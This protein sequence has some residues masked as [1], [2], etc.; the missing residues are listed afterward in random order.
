MLPRFWPVIYDQMCEQKGERVT[1]IQT[2]GGAS[3]TPLT[4]QDSV[5]YHFLHRVSGGHPQLGANL[6]PGGREV[7]PHLSHC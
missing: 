3:S 7:C 4:L 1:L 6:P 2:W 5:P